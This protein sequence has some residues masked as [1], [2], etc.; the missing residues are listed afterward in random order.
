MDFGLRQV[1]R[2][3]LEPLQTP[4][5]RVTERRDAERSARLLK[6][7]LANIGTIYGEREW[8]TPIFSGRV[9]PKTP[10]AS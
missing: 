9:V 3:T 10:S 2:P 5:Q 6:V 7:R 8:K 1:S 4:E